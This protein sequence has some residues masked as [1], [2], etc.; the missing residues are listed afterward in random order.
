[1]IPKYSSQPDA[2]MDP[3]ARYRLVWFGHGNNSDWSGF[4]IF[5][6]TPPQAAFVSRLFQ[7]LADGKPDVSEDELLKAA[8]ATSMSDLFPGSDGKTAAEVWGSLFVRDDQPNTWR[9][10]VP[11][12]AGT[13]PRTDA[14]ATD[15][16]PPDS[17]SDD[18]IHKLIGRK[19]ARVR[20]W[21][22]TLKESAEACAKQARAVREGPRRMTSPQRK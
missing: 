5:T 16:L 6:L 2:P 4:Q 19:K 14:A 20:H 18:E 22:A 7:G 10:N 15:G 13:S 12:P 1:M 11:T 9:L 17:P 8:G 21:L 3:E